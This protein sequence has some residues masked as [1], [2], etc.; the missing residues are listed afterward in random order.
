MYVKV[1][2]EESVNDRP[3]RATHDR[4]KGAIFKW[5]QSGSQTGPKLAIFT[6][7][8]IAIFCPF[9]DVR[10]LCFTDC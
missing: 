8:Q 3:N 2:G 4:R 7:F 5:P 1:N 10:F 6:P 9:E